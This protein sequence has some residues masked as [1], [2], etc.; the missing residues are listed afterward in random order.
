MALNFLPENEIGSFKTQFHSLK[1]SNITDKVKT[2]IWRRAP[3]Y[4]VGPMIHLY[5]S[6]FKRLFLSKHW[7]LKQRRIRWSLW[8]SLLRLN[9]RFYSKASF[10]S[11]CNINKTKQKN[12]IQKMF[13]H[14]WLPWN[15]LYFDFIRVLNLHYSSQFCIIPMW[16]HSRVNLK[17][18]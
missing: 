11:I 4:L 12:I 17:Q 16:I 7:F 10:I 3:T 9:M 15:F 5:H 1:F 14:S 8:W 6:L 13:F 2:R 18:P